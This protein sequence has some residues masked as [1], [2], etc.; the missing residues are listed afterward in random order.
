MPRQ[1]SIAWLLLTILIKVSTQKKDRRDV[2][3]QGKVLYLT[4]SKSLM[5]KKRLYVEE[6]P[7]TLPWYN[8][9]FYYQEPTHQKNQHTKM[10]NDL[11]GQDLN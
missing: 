6:K 11:K 9:I 2:E 3:Y 5:L 8:T 4:H 10:K 7:L 1:N